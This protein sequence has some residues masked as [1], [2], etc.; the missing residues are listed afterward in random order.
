[1][2]QKRV[3]KN[4]MF[5][6]KMG[7]TTI[8]SD[9]LLMPEEAFVKKKGEIK[10]ISVS[11]RTL[12]RVFDGEHVGL[13]TIKSLIKSIGKKHILVNGKIDIEDEASKV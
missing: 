12:R 6:I 8:M 7:V 5:I 2:K 3:T 11:G 4:A 1:M 10:N 9:Q 13:S